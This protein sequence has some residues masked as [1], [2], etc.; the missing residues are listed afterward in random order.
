MGA[1]RRISRTRRA[2]AEGIRREIFEETGLKLSDLAFLRVRTVGKHIEIL[3]RARSDGTP[4]INSNEIKG[5]DWFAAESLPEQM[6]R[7]EKA[8]ILKVV[9]GEFEKVPRL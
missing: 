5:F 9:G 1:A 3:F 8:F 4:Q 6:N 7:D 2:A